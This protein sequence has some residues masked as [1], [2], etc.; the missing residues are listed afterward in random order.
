MRLGLPLVPVVAVRLCPL[1][2]ALY[3]V[4]MG[5]KES[6]VA[7]ARRRFA[8]M[9]RQL[10]DG[11]L[12]A[13]A[14]CVAAAAGGSVDLV[15]P[16]PS[17]ARPSGAPLAAVEGLGRTIEERLSGA[18]WW[19]AALVRA[20]APVRHMQPDVTAYAVPASAAP[21]VAGRRILLV[22]DT[23]VSGARSQSAAGALRARGARAVVIVA[24]GRV[25]RPARSALH[26]D[27]LRHSG[28]DVS[29]RPGPGSWCRC[30]H[31]PARRA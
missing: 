21:L 29:A 6:P 2:G 11:F 18:R 4:L 22:D 19:P 30:V 9:V 7:E 20:H 25:L 24:L 10:L 26:A 16:V 15:L 8:P 12:A 13:H 23:Y 14:G 27:F 1:P 28:A 17:T 31:T 3:T 5:Y